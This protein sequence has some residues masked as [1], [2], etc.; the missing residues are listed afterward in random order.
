MRTYNQSTRHSV[1]VLYLTILNQFKT[2]VLESVPEK[3]VKTFVHLTSGEK[4]PRNLMI[5]FQISQKVLSLSNDLS[6]SLKQNPSDPKSEK[7]VS[8]YQSILAKHATSLFDVTFCYFPITFEPPKN[9]PYGITSLDLK[10]ALRDSLSANGVFASEVFPSLMDKMAASA[11]KVKN[12]ALATIVACIERYDPKYTAPLWKDIWDGLKY[13]VLHGSDETVGGVISS[14]DLTLASL[15]ELAAALLKFKKETAAAP[16]QIEDNSTEGK[17]ADP[18][19]E[20]IKTIVN[21]TIPQIS[22]TTNKKSIPN[23]VLVAGIA[24]ASPFVFEKLSAATLG[25]VLQKTAESTGGITITAQ[26]NLLKIT[27]TF[28]EAATDIRQEVEIEGTG[29]RFA[30]KQQETKELLAI[31][32]L[33]PFKDQMIDLFTK[34]LMGVP[35]TEHE[36]RNLAV[37][38]IASLVCVQQP[39]SSHSNESLLSDEELGLILQY[40]DD[41]LLLESTD[42]SGAGGDKKGRIGLAENILQTLVKVT[43]RKEQLVLDVVYPFF[44]SKLPDSDLASESQQVLIGTI[45]RTLS[46]MA[47]VSRVVFEVFYVRIFNKLDIVLTQGSEKYVLAIF[48]TLAAVLHQLLSV[49]EKESQEALE[50]VQQNATMLSKKLFPLIFTKFLVARSDNKNSLSNLHVVTSASMCLMYIARAL[51]VEAQ[52]DFVQDLFSLFWTMNNATKLVNKGAKLPECYSPFDTK[53]QTPDLSPLAILFLYSVAPVPT[54]SVS[55]PD[56]TSKFNLTGLVARIAQILKDNTLHNDP[57]SATY[58]DQKPLRLVYLRIICVLLNKWVKSSESKPFIEELKTTVSS[59]SASITPNEKALMLSSLEILVWSVKAYLIRNDSLGF[60]TIPYLL[61]LLGQTQHPFIGIV[62]AKLMELL[63]TDDGLI[64]GP[65]QGGCVVRKIYKHRFFVTV[66]EP[67]IKGFEGSEDS[68]GVGNL[69]GAKVNHLVALAGILRWMPSSIITPYVSKFFR[70]LLQSLAVNDERVREASI[71]TITAVV[72]NSE[73]SDGGAILPKATKKSPEELGVAVNSAGVPETKLTA[74]SSVLN[75]ETLW[76]QQDSVVSPTEFISQHLSTLIP[77]LLQ[78]CLPVSNSGS[79]TVVMAPSVRVA[80]LKCLDSFVEHLPI[81]R[82][83]PYT[84]VVIQEL[85]K[86]VDDKRRVVRSEAVRT[87]QK[88]YEIGIQDLED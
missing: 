81:N 55:S 29:E 19:D 49:D 7:I 33:L 6:N 12:E 73:S 46:K 57:K 28:I 31:K 71:N 4:D 53:R 77:A 44:L 21:E 76:N 78:T 82:L 56:F 51:P 79:Q 83:L 84:K 9:D 22:D 58:H 23:S 1:F 39:T 40:L 10:L 15:R 38:N 41:V 50:T 74:A 62:A 65:P 72:L 36:L 20:Y 66:L 42:E 64:A 37:D 13:E 70:L 68:S 34:S 48:S 27:K 59:N 45:L 35:R 75:K 25:Q 88:Y 32:A 54:A 61:S 63:V 18:F 14:Q 47:A 80:A 16:V 2:F 85:G 3:F 11:L 17:N 24:R 43:K 30:R 26:K 69:S 87:R 52:N 60:A 67:L 86:T 5:S 8:T